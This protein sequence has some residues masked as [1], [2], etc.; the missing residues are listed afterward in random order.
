MSPLSC[1]F[2]TYLIRLIIFGKDYISN[3]Q[4]RNV[5]DKAINKEFAY[6]VSH[7]GLSDFLNSLRHKSI[8]CLSNNQNR[9]VSFWTEQDINSQ[10]G[11]D[12]VCDVLLL[13]S[14]PAVSL[15]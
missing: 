3:M 11:P 7:I 15:D 6:H 13:K 4:A 1:I 12:M 10:A 5:L 8:E 2:C 9:T 14:A